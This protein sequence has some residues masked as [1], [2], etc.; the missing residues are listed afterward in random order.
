MDPFTVF[1]SDQMSTAVATPFGT[2]TSD[3]SPAALALDITANPINESGSSFIETFPPL[4]ESLLTEVSQF[5]AEAG[6]VYP[7]LH[8]ETVMEKIQN[9]VY[10]SDQDF[11]ILLMSI[12][13]TNETFKV[14]VSPDRGSFTL[15]LLAKNIEDMRR[16]S[17]DYDFSNA[18]SMDTVVVSICLFCA[19]C[20]C[21]K[22]NR[23]L[24]YLTEAIVLMDMVPEPSDPI[25]IIRLKR[26][27][28]ILFIAESA[29]VSIYG[30]ERN[31]KL[32]R[33]PSILDTPEHTLRWYNGEKGAKGQNWIP[34]S[35]RM[36]ADEEA[37]KLLL[38]MTRLHL[39][40]EVAEVANVSVDNM[41]M[42]NIAKSFDKT[43]YQPFLFSVLIADVGITRQWKLASQW[44]KVLSIGNPLPSSTES[45]QLTIQI[46]GMS[47]LQWSRTLEPSQLRIVGPGKLVALADTIL[48]ISTKL[49]NIESCS[50]ILG[51]LINSVLAV[52][53]ERYFAPRLS[54]IELCIA[55]VPRPI[56]TH[57]DFDHCLPEV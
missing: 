14:A 42:A 9:E 51:D 27:E 33:R 8:W 6:V 53:Y 1:P 22:H 12:R 3:L 39:A 57:D 26:L 35:E 10:L 18:P 34:D 30:S 4:R 25:E 43:S 47:T 37:V 21:N 13:M 50:S 55:H 40:S 44:W 52:D 54:I 16:N 19:Y 28:Y 45:L 17:G 29:S 23:A 48:N 41:M 24:C 32:A 11:H 56:V 31:R 38:L 36:K 2:N 49:G 15:S 46:L 7:V 5:F 20:V